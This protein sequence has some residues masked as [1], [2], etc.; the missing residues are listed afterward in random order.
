MEYY[1]VKE[2]IKPS[3]DISPM[4]RMCNFTKSKLTFIPM[5]NKKI[6][7][8]RGFTNLSFTNWSDDICNQ[9]TIHQLR[10]ICKEKGDFNDRQPVNLK[11]YDWYANLKTFEEDKFIYRNIAL[12][13]GSSSQI[14]ILDIDQ[15]KITYVE[16]GVVKTMK[17]PYC[18]I[19]ALLKVINK[20][21]LIDPNPKISYCGLYLLNY[22]G[23]KDF[24]TYIERT[25]SGGY[26]LYFNYVPELKSCTGIKMKDVDQLY[27][28]DILNDNKWAV[29][30]PSVVNVD[31]QIKSYD[32]IRE[33]K[34]IDMPV[35]L[36][37][38]LLEATSKPVSN[39]PKKVNY[40]KPSYD[41][42]ERIVYNLDI[43]RFE[44]YDDWFKLVSIL[45]T[46]EDGSERFH[47]LI[48]LVTYATGR[49]LS[50][51]EYKILNECIDT[52]KGPT[53]GTLIFWLK[54]DRPDD[55]LDILRTDGIDKKKIYDR[56][57]D[58]SPNALTYD[59]F[60]MKY[61]YD[62]VLDTYKA[63]NEYISDFYSVI[64]PMNDTFIIKKKDDENKINFVELKTKLALK[65]MK[66]HKYFYKGQYQHLFVKGIKQDITDEAN[67]I[68][69]ELALFD[70]YEGEA[71]PLNSEEAIK[72][73]MSDYVKK[74]VKRSFP[75]DRQSEFWLSGL[76]FYPYA[77]N[78][79]NR[80]P[81]NPTYHNTFKG[82]KAKFINGKT[83][84]ELEED[85]DI[86]TLRSLLKDICG[87]SDDNMDMFNYIENWLARNFQYPRSKAIT[88]PIF[89]GEQGVGKSLFWNFVVIH[90]IG[91]DYGYSGSADTVFAD[92]NSHNA[93]MKL[94][95]MEEKMISGAH[96]ETLKFCS[97]ELRMP[98]NEKYQNVK[99]NFKNYSSYVL[100]TNDENWP[101]NQRRIV[102]CYCNNDKSNNSISKEGIKRKQQIIQDISSQKAGDGNDDEKYPYYYYKVLNRPDPTFKYKDKITKK[103][104]E[105]TLP[106]TF[107]SY[108]TTTDNKA[109][110]KQTIVT[111][112]NK[113]IDQQVEEAQNKKKADNKVHWQK[114]GNLLQSDESFTQHREKMNN[115]STDLADKY[116]TY[117][118]QKDLSNF[119]PQANVVK[120]KRQSNRE[121]GTVCTNNNF[122]DFAQNIPDTIE[123]DDCPKPSNKSP[124]DRRIDLSGLSN[125]KATYLYKV[126]LFY[127]DKN[128]SKPLSKLVFNN[129]LDSYT[130]INGDKI[131]TYNGI[132][133]GYKYYS[134]AN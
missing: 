71:H 67:K 86:I 3:I 33:A 89:F 124:Q 107:E 34:I 93:N 2:A 37:D 29:C 47:N 12:K 50:Q 101:N 10:S 42:V 14:T 131:F 94:I 65:S 132:I 23:F 63:N 74:E 110:Y 54:N 53:I 17:L 79:T 30:Y 66:I 118:M 26:H 20:I 41:L 58:L 116:F 82:F 31:G 19:D 13:C 69:P 114:I 103:T 15:T 105:Y 78:E 98:L 52:D 25:P 27:G 75:L 81:L 96:L 6:D 57:M 36:K 22:I 73:S 99:V 122:E 127:C 126:Y 48:R 9:A 16:N 1:N 55:Y 91:E 72:K 64:R 28:I 45:K 21:K 133:G 92:F 4:S 100:N 115:D 80:I 44:S 39:K 24:N 62:D 40:E 60:I 121:E 90:M 32:V 51:L 70:E 68:Q 61:K 43:T 125:Y 120:D 7:L 5:L 119:H 56:F 59:D 95:V 85:P 97:S 77:I 76:T 117:L 83:N 18:D 104:D 11:D 123:Y 130:D 35:E 46:L 108:N 84:K 109:F 113:Y 38:F 8:C 129:N 112:V 102:V 134:L 106:D 87:S 49:H 111:K 128:K 88:V